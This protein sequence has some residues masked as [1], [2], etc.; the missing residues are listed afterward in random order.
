MTY[1]D[2]YFNV[3][4]KFNKIHEILEKEIF[5]KRK[6]HISV[7]DLNAAELLSDFLYTA[8]L[9][10]FL[11]HTIIN[12]EERAPVHIDWEHKLL[13]DDFLVN[14]KPDISSFFSR[15]LRLIEIVSNDEE[16]KK[17]ARDRLK[18][19]RDRGYEIKL[20]DATKEI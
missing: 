14:L 1:I 3:E 18:F 20:I 11:P 9:T 17:K 4:N 12:H 10:S 6:I 7:S 13:S 15:Y 8:S 5:R 19:Y 2:F 16:D